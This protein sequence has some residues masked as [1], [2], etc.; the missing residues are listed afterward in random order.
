MQIP[1]QETLQ[2]IA[3]Q[4]GVSPDACLS[5]LNQF[6][7]FYEGC[8]SAQLFPPSELILHASLGWEQASGIEDAA[9]VLDLIT[10]YFLNNAIDAIGN[11][12]E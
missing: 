10:A 3:T 7:R 1:T 8:R 5:Y 11:I 12:A 6:D 4:H 9:I 2:S